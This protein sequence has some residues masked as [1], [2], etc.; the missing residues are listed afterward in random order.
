MRRSPESWVAAVES[1]DGGTN[2]GFLGKGRRNASYT[3]G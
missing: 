2:D 3:S 1:I